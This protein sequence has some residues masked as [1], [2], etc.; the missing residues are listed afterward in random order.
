MQ[1]L[2]PLVAKIF[3]QLQKAGIKF[4]M[5]FI[6]EDPYPMTGSI[7]DGSA[8]PKPLTT[9]MISATAKFVPSADHSKLVAFANRHS[10]I[11]PCALILV[12]IES[13]TGS[14]GSSGSKGS[15]GAKAGHSKAG[16]SSHGHSNAAHGAKKAHKLFL[17]LQERVAI[18]KHSGS[19]G[20]QGGSGSKKGKGGSAG[21]ANAWGKSASY[22]QLKGLTIPNVFVVDLDLEL[23]ASGDLT[24]PFSGIT[25]KGVATAVEGAAGDLLGGGGKGGLKGK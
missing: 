7:E 2:K 20:K 1:K 23:L 25:A 17:E 3:S 8:A 11:P 22:V 10:L 5:G 4:S 19:K 13:P 21:G 9:T 16:H 18:S 14:S 24:K 12:S 15:K 6:L